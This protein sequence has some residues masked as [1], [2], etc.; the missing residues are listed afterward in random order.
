MSCH[1]FNL[2]MDVLYTIKFGFNR[3]KLLAIT[4][5]IIRESTFLGVIAAAEFNQFYYTLF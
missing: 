3:S 4:L 2:K 1:V 5:I